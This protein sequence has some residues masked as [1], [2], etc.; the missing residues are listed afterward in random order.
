MSGHS[1]WAKIKRQKGANDLKKGAVFTKL[2]RNIT[3]AAKEGG[4]E[5]NSNFALRLA[6]TK[7]KDMNMPMNNIER[8]IQKGTGSGEKIALQK[9]SYE[10]IAPG[11]INI[12][13][14]CQ[15]DNTNRTFSE[16]KNIVDKMGAKITS[17]GSI[18]W[19]FSE[20]GYIALSSAKL[21]KSTQFG[22]KDS[23]DPVD[24]D[25]VQLELME[26][27]GIEDLEVQKEM[28]LELGAYIIEIYTSKEEFSKVLK[29]LEALPYKIETAELIKKAKENL[30]I[31]AGVK[32][33][34][35]NLLE[36]LENLDD[37]DNVWSNLQ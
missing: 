26:I 27:P 25:T 32:I 24:P 10:I 15:S 19:Q 5:I 34:I 7:A 9:I 18:S 20:K 30:S 35:E 28:D 11:G 4:G 33:K 16:V 2:A 8:A 12:I 29:N 23:Y 3:L 17:A 36:A 37:V 22:K 6:V 13:V 31:A 14:D 1:K 21:Q